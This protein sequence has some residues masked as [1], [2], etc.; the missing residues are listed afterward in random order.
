[1]KNNKFQ[2]IKVIAKTFVL[3]N[4]LLYMKFYLKNLLFR[5][6]SLYLKSKPTKINNI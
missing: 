1:M 5:V 3:I 2:I 6:L 4:L